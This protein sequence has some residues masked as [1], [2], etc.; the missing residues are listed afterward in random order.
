MSN[1]YLGKPNFYDF[2]YSR[3]DKGEF[4][5]EQKWI[6]SRSMSIE[7]IVLELF[8]FRCLFAGRSWLKNLLDTEEFL[9]SR[10]D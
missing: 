3:I 8:D 5:N 4:S 7:S 1:I 6:S 2:F 9:N 10:N